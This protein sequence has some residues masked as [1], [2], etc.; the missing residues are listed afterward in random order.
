MSSRKFLYRLIL[1]FFILAQFQF[2]AYLALPSFTIP[3]T[4]ITFNPRSIS[5]LN[6]PHI[7][8][9]GLSSASA[10]LS[11]SRL[12]FFG[13]TS[14]AYSAGVTVI[15]LGTPANVVGD[16]NTGNLFPNDSVSIKNSGG[17]QVASISGSTIF[18]LKNSL[19]IAV[20]N[21]D[22]IYSTE[23]GSLTVNFRTAA[24]VPAGGSI[25]LKIPAVLAVAP[26]IGPTDGRPDTGNSIPNNGFDTNTMT[27]ANV[28][29]PV[30][31]TAG[32][33]TAATTGGPTNPHKF[34][35]NT[36]SA[37]PAGADFTITVGTGGKEL[38]NPAPI[39]TSHTQGLADVYKI[40]LAT[41]DTSD[42]TGNL[43]EDVDV[44]VAPVEGVLVTATV[45]E[46]LTFQIAGVTADSSAYCGVTRTANSVD[47]TATSVPW[48]IINS[49]YSSDKN[50][51]VQ[52]L[53][54]STNATTGY[55]VYAESND[56]MGKDGN[57]CTGAVPSAPESTFGTGVCIRN[58]N[59]GGGG[60][61]T[62]THTTT[63]DWAQ[64]PNGYGFGYS[65]IKADGADNAAGDATFTWGTAAQF[66]ARQFADKEAAS[67]SASIMTNAGPVSGSAVYVCYKIAIPPLQ[68]AGYYFNK[69]KYTAVAKF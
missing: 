43:V 25:Y 7:D 19:P 21:G 44:A 34:T 26:E 31:F 49:I 51:A 58:A 11:N 36:A 50:N 22:S 56:Q 32:T 55:T 64:T 24:A 18:T 57:T 29:C 63:G 59:C 37:I 39:N 53:T 46:T 65:L 16:I 54:V 33:Y 2:I 60:Y 23:S 1:F 20:A 5:L 15:T 4:R 40:N 67:S 61:S 68:P 42:G 6:P 9:T 27:S 3:G 17:I 52:Q 69:V 12:S 35:C 28:T 8:A 62:C 13:R 45:D 14:T 48:G 38:I 47:T 41:T 30:G 10:T 66:N